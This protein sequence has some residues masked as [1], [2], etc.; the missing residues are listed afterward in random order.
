MGLKSFQPSY[1]FK[2]ILNNYIIYSAWLIAGI[3]YIGSSHSQNIDSKVIYFKIFKE[4]K[5][6]GPEQFPTSYN[7]KLILNNYIIYWRYNNTRTRT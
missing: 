7:F 1:N 5:P 2:L 6:K 4:Q 3:T